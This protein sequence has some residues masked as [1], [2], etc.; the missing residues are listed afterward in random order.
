VCEQL[1]VQLA[2]L[3][4]GDVDPERLLI[5][6]RVSKDLDEYTQRTR[7]V[8]ALE[9]AETQSFAVAPGEDI[10]YVVVDDE[11][12]SAA[13]VQLAYESLDRYDANF[14]GELLVR[15]AESV[16]AP[17]GWDRTRIRQYLADRQDAAITMY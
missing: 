10:R 6:R 12:D 4:S 1:K 8:A 2:E 3:R 17:F 15:A 11:K 9:R 5:R 13:R 7:N 14:Y 16:L